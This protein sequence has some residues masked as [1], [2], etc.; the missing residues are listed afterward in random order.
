MNS[1]NITLASDEDRKHAESRKLTLA[2][3]HDSVTQE[4]E[5]DSVSVSR[6]VSAGPV[7]NIETDR[8]DSSSLVGFSDALHHTDSKERNLAKRPKTSLFRFTPE[9]VVMVVFAAT[10]ITATALFVIV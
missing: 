4:E 1:Q 8:E 9:S 2:P 6:H 3:I 7:G 10:T 5:F